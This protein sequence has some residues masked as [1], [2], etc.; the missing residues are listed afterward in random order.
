MKYYTMGTKITKF[1]II[2]FLFGYLSQSSA[3]KPEF[4][5]YGW[6]LI[7]A[8]YSEGQTR[9]GY[10]SVIGGVGT[11]FYKYYGIIYNY[12]FNNPDN[13]YYDWL[14]TYGYTLITA[15]K[16]ASLIHA[17]TDLELN[18]V[19]TNVVSLIEASLQQ[20]HDQG[21]AVSPNYMWDPI[22]S[23][24][25]RS[26]FMEGRH[27]ENGNSEMINANCWGNANYLTKSFNWAYGYAEYKQY[28][29]DWL[30]QSEWGASFP[31]IYLDGWIY[32]NSYSI[33]GD[34]YSNNWRYALEGKG[35][36]GSL[37]NIINSFDVIR[38]SSNP[39]S[40]PNDPYSTELV[41]H[42][43]SRLGEN[44]HCAAYIC[45]D[46]SGKPWFYEKG[47]YGATSYAPYGIRAFGVDPNW[48]YENHY[49]S[50][51]RHDGDYKANLADSYEINW[52]GI[53]P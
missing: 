3:I 9:A 2:C 5:S 4:N 45:T 48:Q 46:N 50:Y 38:M 52:Y 24:K 1:L 36:T 35:T 51:F 20:D 26:S 13:N 39:S 47:N 43:G 25:W 28:A 11:W 10:N 37:N 14:P 18:W 53:T 33:D 32:N 6:L 17:D 23:W 16:L 41:W 15:Q 30:G 8:E 49:R 7:N 44:A 12:S 22:E 21:I 34:M 19:P 29:L 31:H 40:P 27:A 42:D